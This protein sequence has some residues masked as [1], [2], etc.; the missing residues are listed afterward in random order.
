MGGSSRFRPNWLEWKVERASRTFR[1]HVV[2]P[3]TNDPPKH[4]ALFRAALQCFLPQQSTEYALP[5]DPNPVI[6]PISTPERFDLLTFPEAFL[7][8]KT[9][10]DTLLFLGRTGIRLG[11]VHT[12]IRPTDQ[13]EMTHLFDVRELTAL[14]SQLSQVPNFS[15]HDLV[16][17]GNWLVEQQPSD[18]FNI[19]C[20]FA[21]DAEGKLRAC[22]H[23]KLVRSKF[24]VSPEHERHM[25]EANLLS[26]VTLRPTDVNLSSITLQ[27]LICSDMLNTDTD[28]PNNHPLRATSTHRSV[29]PQ[30]HADE[31]DV[32]SV[33]TCS[34]NKSL[35]GSDAAWH[36]KFRES[37]QRAAADDGRHRYAAIV[38]AN[39]HFFQ[40]DPPSKGGLSGVFVPLPIYSSPYDPRVSA[41]QCIY[42]R[43][44]SRYDSGITEED[45]RW[46]GDDGSWHDGK[47]YHVL[48]YIVSLASSAHRPDSA[49]TMFGFTVSRL[50][51]DANRW[52]RNGSVNDFSVHHAHPTAD[53][54]FEFLIQAVP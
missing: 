54:E 34:P 30:V 26:L 5:S 45:E 16:P 46:V 35:S 23:A 37:F 49:A 25:K 38:L 50:P 52:T 21:I 12:G 7:P 1:V 27:P 48:G 3:A 36:Q 10:V 4:A 44:P 20:L 42:G 51:K 41:A 15:R 28:E 33:A 24:E 9:L 43:F 19:G 47:R 31:I 17:F 14:L 6:A 29:F 18:R 8:K 13:P 22:L 53:G 40:V 2:E 11:C 32:V 39:Y